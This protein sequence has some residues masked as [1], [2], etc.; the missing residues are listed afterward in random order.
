MSEERKCSACGKKKAVSEMKTCMHNQ[1]HRYVCDTKCMNDFYSPPKKVI[2]QPAEAEGVELTGE[3]H[4]DCN[5][6]IAALSAVTAERDRLLQEREGK[7]LVPVEPTI[8]MIAALG[9]GGDVALA[10]GH[11][12]ISAEVEQT[13]KAMLNAAMAAKEE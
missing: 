11:A 13:Y 8:E 12:A 7:A 1:M 10:I 3:Y 5:R 9:F 4:A 6:L 2:A